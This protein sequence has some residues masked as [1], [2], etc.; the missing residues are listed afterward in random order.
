LTLLVVP[1]F[2]L[3]IDDG[4]EWIKA[5]TRRLLGRDEPAGREASPAG[6]AGVCGGESSGRVDPTL[7]L[8]VSEDLV[9]GLLCRL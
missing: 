6:S 2:Y 5:T 7:V 4:A 8:E 1:V 3:L 9:D